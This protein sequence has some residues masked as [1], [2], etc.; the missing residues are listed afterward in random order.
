VSIAKLGGGFPPLPLPI[1]A[2]QA[3]AD[4]E[5]LFAHLLRAEYD[6]SMHRRSERRAVRGL[7]ILLVLVAGVST[8]VDAQTAATTD[9]VFA[10]FVSQLRI[11]VS[12]PR[13]RVSWEDAAD[14]ITTYRIY[15]STEAITNETFSDA[16][17]VGSVDPGTEGFIDVPPE[18]GAYYYAVVAEN[19]SGEPYPVIIPGRNA[20]FHD[21]AIENVAT[22][23]SRAARVRSIDATVVGAEGREAVEITAVATRDERTLAVY[24]STEPITTEADLL[25]AA[26][27]REVPSDEARL[28]DLPVPGVAY[29]YAAVDA[30]LLLAGGLEIRPG[31]NSTVEPVEIPLQVATGRQEEPAERDQRTDTVTEARTEPAV[32][33]ADAPADG[34][35]FV[36]ETTTAGRGVPLPFLQLENRL[37][38]GRRL[39]DPRILIPRRTEIGP[40]TKASLDRLLAGLTPR[41]SRTDEPMILPVDRLPDPEGAE[42]TLRTILDGPF[43]RMAWESALVQLENYFTL[44]LTPDLAARAHFYRAQVYHFLGDDRTAVLEFLLARDAYYVEVAAWLDRILGS[45]GA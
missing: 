25:E 12:D 16:E 29:Y 27:V 5:N 3:H 2:R 26:L 17:L 42:Y 40:E 1:R 38:T 18:P 22:E 15:R 9:R 4:E 13:I 32:Q 41:E 30:A 45:G 10:P 24:R 39:G 8:T 20:S 19:A 37:S 23:A 7:S 33:P 43:A 14:V 34:P 11:S 6:S 28:I 31:E 35:V 21:V 36:P 44:P